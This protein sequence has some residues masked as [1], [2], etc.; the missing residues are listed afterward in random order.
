MNIQKIFEA[1]KEDEM[2]SALGIIVYELE[3][4]G[5]NI[6]IMNIPIK[7][8]E[9]FEG[10]YEDLER[11]PENTNMKIYKNRALEQTFAIEFIDLHEPIFKR[12]IEY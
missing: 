1:L 10:K 5:Y 9:L 11:L 6:E 8:S 2:N 7:S 4:Q 3:Q 12:A